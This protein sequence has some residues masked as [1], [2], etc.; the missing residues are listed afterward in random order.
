MAHFR[1]GRVEVNHIVQPGVARFL[2]AASSPTASSRDLQAPLYDA[3]RA[4][5]KSLTLASQ[6]RGFS[7][8]M[9]VWEWM[10]RAG[11]EVPALFKDPVYARMKQGKVVTSSLTTGWLEGGFIHPFPGSIFVCFEARDDW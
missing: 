3:V 9:L 1:K 5:S 11:E 4:H 2:A 10:I 8:H 6:G 7:R